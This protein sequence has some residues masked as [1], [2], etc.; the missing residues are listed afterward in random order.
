[1]EL[2]FVVL[3]GLIAGLAGRAVLRNRALL[4]TLLLPA[5]GGEEMAVIETADPSIWVSAVTT[6]REGD[7]LIAVADLVPA[8]AKPFALDP[9]TLRFTVLAGERAVDIQGC[10]NLR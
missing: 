4:G 10:A 9:A 5:I 2:L 8:N 3:I 1:M 6:T 7:A